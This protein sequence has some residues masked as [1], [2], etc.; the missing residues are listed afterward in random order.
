MSFHESTLFEVS[1]INAQQHLLLNQFELLTF[2]DIISHFTWETKWTFTYSFKV[3]C[4]I[5]MKAWLRFL[6]TT[7]HLGKGE[8]TF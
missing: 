8:L 1:L 6:F 4:K 7:L 2:A 5:P 3:L